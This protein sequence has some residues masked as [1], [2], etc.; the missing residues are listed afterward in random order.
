M[1]LH[2]TRRTGAAR[3][4][5]ASMNDLSKFMSTSIQSIFRAVASDFVL[6]DAS[7]PF[8]APF[9]GGKLISG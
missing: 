5:A 4:G 2:P 8:V 1:A 7:R 6:S 3:P 9:V